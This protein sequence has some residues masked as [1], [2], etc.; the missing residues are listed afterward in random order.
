VSFHLS[1]P[2]LERP[3]TQ[4]FGAGKLDAII[5]CAYIMQSVSYLQAMMGIEL[6]NVRADDVGVE[7]HTPINRHAHHRL[8]G[9]PPVFPQ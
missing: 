5:F 8:D 2:I 7:I 3:A 1:A 6:P 4:Q 9:N